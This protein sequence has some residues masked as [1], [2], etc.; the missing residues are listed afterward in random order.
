MSFSELVGLVNEPNTPSG[1]HES[2]R[3]ICTAVP[4]DRIERILD[5]GSNTGFA[6]VEF[7]SLT[8]AEVR[9]IDIN[10]VSVAHARDLA[11]RL[12]ISNA[13]FQVG[14]IL[15]LP[16][17]DATFNLV[18]CNNVTSF[19][20]DRAKAIAEYQRV[21]KPGGILAAVPIYY[22]ESPPDVLVEQ[23]SKA[24]DAPIVVRDIDQWHATFEAP[25]LHPYYRADFVYDH[26]STETVSAYADRVTAPERLPDLS[27]GDRAAARERLTYFYSL[28]NENLRYCGFSVLI[29]RHRPPNAFPVLQA[30]RRRSSP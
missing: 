15:K 19:I 23:V 7:A 30:S 8:R 11:A 16:F 4:M 14:D 22:I 6:S 3:Q 27:D 20:R 21:L 13:S 1:A 10:P 2:I 12:G 24:I 18:Y 26:L 17:E 5:V 29:Y 9:G 28:F 25:D